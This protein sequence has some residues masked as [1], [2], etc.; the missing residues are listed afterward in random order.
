M[1]P[2][3]SSL[4]GRVKSLERYG[5][6]VHHVAPSMLARGM[7]WRQECI[8]AAAG[9]SGQQWCTCGNHPTRGEASE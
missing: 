2:A 9:M 6:A 4:M 1:K 7:L 3:Y 8:H 5:L